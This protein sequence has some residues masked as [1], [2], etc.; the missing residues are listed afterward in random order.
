[1]I[2]PDI[3]IFFV[4]PVEPSQIERPVSGGDLDIVERDVRRWQQ[5]CDVALSMTD[6]LAGP[7]RFQVAAGVEGPEAGR[8]GGRCARAHPGI[9]E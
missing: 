6:H 2:T 8:G 5:R 1:M 3:S 4:E 9:S 7:A